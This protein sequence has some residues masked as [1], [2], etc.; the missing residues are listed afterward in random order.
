MQRYQPQFWR[1]VPFVRLL[2]PYAAGV[3]LSGQ[4]ALSLR[5]QAICLAMGCVIVFAFRFLPNTQKYTWRWVQGISLNLVFLSLG[6]LCMFFRNIAHR[7]DWVGN[8]PANTQYI[9]VSLEE[10][11]TEKSRSFKA[12]ANVESV[13]HDRY[14]QKASGK[15]ILYF[16]KDAADTSLQY[17]SQLLIAKPLQLIN[18]A[19]NPGGFDYKKYCAMQDIYHQLYLQR[20]EY[21]IT[22]VLHKSA[23]NSWLADARNNVLAIFRRWVP[24]GVEA[25]VAEALLIG[26][27]NDLDK[28]LVRAY[29]N[30]GVVHIIAISGLHLGM[31]YGLMLL[32]LKPFQKYNWIR[33][34]KPVA[35]LLVLWGF[36]L[37]A[38]AAAS[39][40]RS[41][42]MFSFIVA[43][44]SFGR[45]TNVY[46]TLAASAFC[47]LVYD[48][49]FFWDVGFQL[50]YTAVLSI[51]LF[52]KPVY[53]WFY[54]KN[55]LLNIVWELNSITIAAQ[56]LTLPVILYYFHQFPNLFLFTNFIA[57]PLSGFILYG[58]LLLLIVCK[59]PLVN[60]YTGRIVSFL[61]RQ[62]NRLIERT[63]R[64]P[65]AVTD[66]ISFDIAQAV[67]LYFAICYTA[68]WMLRRKTG[69]M[70]AGLSFAVLYTLYTDILWMMQSH[71]QKIIVYNIP[72]Q[73][74]VDWIKGKTF[75]LVSESSLTRN[76]WILQQNI[77]PA[78]VLYGCDEGKEAVATG[79][80]LMKGAKR[81]VLMIGPGFRLRPAVSKIP[82]DLVI[83]HHNPQLRISEL[84]AVFTCKQY[85]F[86]NSNPLWKIRYWK[87]DADS[88]HL[89]HHTISEQGAFEMDL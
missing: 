85:V 28:D 69:G 18:S 49:Y 61:V 64:L 83:L 43:G 20:S 22:G 72:K 77:T 16:R 36:S 67:L 66:H 32:L 2:L 30:T 38:G 53:R 10:P 29:S 55:K 46:N 23:L 62:M 47:L 87:K 74:A 13:Y 11:L 34:V 3:V 31:I 8:A 58:E 75:F 1:T 9:C 89:R 26:Y 14:W 19:G 6:C 21:T 24:G 86:D 68:W 79:I 48:P 82:V 71:Q 17:G 27:R 57:V 81:T 78:R 40:L 59:V 4:V 35:I 80:M 12:I 33:W 45:R 56:V 70:I 65:F 84:D 50:S 37:L 88:L 15:L 63:G 44:E 76:A 7:D 25:G 52:M 51:M 5:L 42:V 60:D 41:V 54:F 39:I 73:T